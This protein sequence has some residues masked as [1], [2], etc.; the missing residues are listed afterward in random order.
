MAISEKI[1]KLSKNLRLSRRGLAIPVT[2]LILF[3]SLMT[4][5]SATY[6]FAVAKIS[7]KSK[8]LNVAAAEQNMI[9][10]DSYISSVLWNEKSS[11]VYDF[12]DCGGKLKIEPSTVKLSINISGN[13]LNERI[14]DYFI[15]KIV[16]ELPSAEDVDIGVYL[17]GGSRVVVNGSG[18]T[19]TKLFIINGAEKPEINLYYRPMVSVVE[20]G[21]ESGKPLNILRIYVINMNSSRSLQLMGEVSIKISCVGV[22]FSLRN[23]NFSS[24]VN[25]LDINVNLNGQGGQVSVPIASNENGAIVQVEVVTCQIKVERGQ[26]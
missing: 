10:L 13:G 17:K 4:L 8:S 16:Y 22:S 5:I 23:Y 24:Q 21:V 18:N 9:L 11:T 1:R 19:M 2:F 3:V 26:K 15:G 20:N 6:Y 25:S 7:S 12:S 14:Y